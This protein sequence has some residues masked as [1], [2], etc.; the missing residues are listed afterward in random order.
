MNKKK[1]QEVKEH[2]DNIS[3]SI[4]RYKDMDL[5]Y[6]NCDYYHPRMA[7]AGAGTIEFIESE[8]QKLLQVMP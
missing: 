4:Q 1:T 3:Q 5:S 8:I 2:L 7:G 6:K